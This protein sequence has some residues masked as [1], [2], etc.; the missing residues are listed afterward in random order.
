MPEL[1]PV[2]TAT[3][4][5]PSSRPDALSAGPDARSAGPDARSTGD[6]STGPDARSA[7]PSPGRG[8]PS[9]GPVRSSTPRFCPV[10]ARGYRDLN[11][12]IERRCGT[13]T[14]GRGDAQR[15]DDVQRDGTEAVPRCSESAVWRGVWGDHGDIAVPAVV[16]SRTRFERQD[17]G[18]G[19]GFAGRP[20]LPGSR[21][22]RS[23]VG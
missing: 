23:T 16:S 3:G 11:P 20:G 12:S 2:T 15:R 7:A 1:A 5:S 8:T 6:R 13:Q 14:P 10:M 22:R 4:G 17:A 21:G 18:Q 9:A 19:T